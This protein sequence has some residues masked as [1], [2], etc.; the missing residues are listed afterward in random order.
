M[1]STIL[2]QVEAV[3]KS[4]A[5]IRKITNEIKNARLYDVFEFQVSGYSSYLGK[6]KN[7]RRH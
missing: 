5:S 1:Y 4:A 6:L 7:Y 3:Q 2:S